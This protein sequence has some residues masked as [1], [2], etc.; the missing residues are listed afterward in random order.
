M[1]YNDHILS[2]EECDVFAFLPIFSVIDWLSFI[3]SSPK[4]MQLKVLMLFENKGTE[5]F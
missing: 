1:L 3:R 4:E 2:R 5:E